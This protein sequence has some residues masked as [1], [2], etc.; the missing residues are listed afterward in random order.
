MQR[1]N[2]LIEYLK[3]FLQPQILGCTYVMGTPSKVCIS[4]YHPK[5]KMTQVNGHLAMAETPSKQSGANKGGDGYPEVFSPSKRSYANF[6]SVDGNYNSAEEA[7]DVDESSTKKLK[8]ATGSRDDPVEV[9]GSGS[10]GSEDNE[11]SG[12]M[13]R[14]A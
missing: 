12:E 4:I 10:D 9:E 6:V 7:S 8:A 5:H 13:T 2:L 1:Y 3:V 11:S 14:F